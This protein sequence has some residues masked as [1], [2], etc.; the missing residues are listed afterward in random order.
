MKRATVLCLALSLFFGL[1]A[2]GQDSTATKQTIAYGSLG[3]LYPFSEGRGS[4]VN[5]SLVAQTKANFLL[6]LGF[7]AV[8]YKD[9]KYDKKEAEINPPIHKIKEF[10]FSIGGL[11]PISRKVFFTYST[12]PSFVK[13]EMPYNITI[14]TGG[15]GGI[16]RSSSYEYDTKEFGLFGWNAKTE[17]AFLLGESLGLTTGLTA[18]ATKEVAYGGVYVG[19]TIGDFGLSK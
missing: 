9:R 14:D 12:G 5:L 6:S 17:F 18:T 11:A 1:E 13:Y 8:N 4:G 7:T 3:Y 16:I 10:N 15:W 19:L 2:A